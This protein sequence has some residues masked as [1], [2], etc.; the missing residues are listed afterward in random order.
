MIRYVAMLRRRDGDVLEDFLATWLGEHR[1]LALALPLVRR[2]AFHP[3]VRGPGPDPDYDGVGF[4]DFDSR[5]DLERSLSSPEARHLRQ[6]T[7]TFADPERVARA[8]IE[9]TAPATATGPGP[10]DG[11]DACCAPT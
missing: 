9:L 7:G 8:V 1:S 4:L 10:E 3:T 2:V 11:S 6:H 5:A